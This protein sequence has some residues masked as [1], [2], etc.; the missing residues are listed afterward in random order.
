MAERLVLAELDV[1]ST[2]LKSNLID[3]RAAFDKTATTVDTF[4]KRARETADFSDVLTRRM[5]SLRS[6]AVALLGSFTLAGHLP[7]WLSD[8]DTDHRNRVVQELQHRGRGCL[9][10]AG[11]G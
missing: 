7:A 10:G 5:F 6:A 2:Q 1:D 11:E 4:G 3:A 8:Q 9:P